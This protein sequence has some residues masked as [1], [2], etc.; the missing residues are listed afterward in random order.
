[1]S[2]KLCAPAQGRVQRTHAATQAATLGSLYHISK[3]T[4][5]VPLVFTKKHGI[6][7][8]RLMLRLW[9]A[10]AKRTYYTI[11]LL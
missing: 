9:L 11:F 8:A 5:L 10:F 2:S 1:M 3:L 4:L 7:A 6:Y